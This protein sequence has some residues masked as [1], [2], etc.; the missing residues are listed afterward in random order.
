VSQLLFEAQT[1]RWC[2]SKVFALCAGK[3][4]VGS[5]YLEPGRCLVGDGRSCLDSG[6]IF[7]RSRRLG[8][9]QE[10]RSLHPFQMFVLHVSFHKKF[11]RAIDPEQSTRTLEALSHIERDTKSALDVLKSISM[12]ETR[13]WTRFVY[14][15]ACN[16]RISD[17]DKQRFWNKVEVTRETPIGAEHDASFGEAH[18]DAEAKQLQ[19]LLALYGQLNSM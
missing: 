18:L 2:D 11:R 9:A 8:A 13:E 3:N 7:G 4:P 19:Q 15:I 12:S 1:V 6:P 10:G 5:V 16:Q 14:E 17:L